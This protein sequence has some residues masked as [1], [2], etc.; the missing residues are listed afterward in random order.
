MNAQYGDDHA[1]KKRQQALSEMFR[2][3]LHEAPKDICLSPV[4]NNL[5]FLFLLSNGVHVC[6]YL[7]LDLEKALRRQYGRLSKTHGESRGQ[8][9]K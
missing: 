3:V 6:P 2:A 1:W 8:D 5:I 9:R 4:S 7:K